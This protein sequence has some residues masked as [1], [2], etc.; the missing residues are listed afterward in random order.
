MRRERRDDHAA[1]GATNAVGQGPANLVLGERGARPVDVRGV[2]HEAEDPALPELGEPVVV[3]AFAVDRIRVE[4]EVPRV[5]DRAHWRLD[6]VAEPVHDR[7][8]HPER[9]HAE[10]ADV[11]GPTWLDRH[12]PR[13]VLEPVLA[14]PL[15]GQGESHA[16]PVDRDVE[17]TKEVR[18]RADV[19][20]VGVRQDHPAHLIALGEE[21]GEVRDDVVDPRHLVVGEHESAVDGQEVL[22]R[23]EHHHVE[24]DLAEAAE[25]EDANAGLDRRVARSPGRRAGRDDAVGHTWA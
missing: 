21:G 14:E 24:A 16:R 10:A 7:V 20:L 15:A 6:A 11:E 5:H 18:Q 19:V 12:E 25:R 2:R 4:L 1:R 17:L 13:P 22:A 9:L 23:L 3:G 8:R